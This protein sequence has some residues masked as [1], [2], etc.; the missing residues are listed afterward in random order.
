MAT[1]KTAALKK[2]RSAT[3][4]QPHPLLAH[5]PP[6]TDLEREQLEARIRT[7]GQ[8]EAIEVYQKQIIAGVYEYEACVATKTAPRFTE[9]EPVGDLTDYMMGRN[10]PRSMLDK[11]RACIAVLVYRPMAMAALRKKMTL[12]RKSP[13]GATRWY[14]HAARVCN[15]TKAN[16]EICPNLVKRLASILDEDKA[17][18]EAIRA[19]RITVMSDAKALIEE[20][21]WDHGLTPDKPTRNPNAAADRMEVL[22]RYEQGDKKPRDMSIRKLI[23]DLKREKRIKLLPPPT[24]KGKDWAVYEGDMAKEGQRI[25]DHSVNAVVADIIYGARDAPPMAVKVGKLSKRVLIEG[26]TLA[27]MCG[28]AAIPA[29]ITAIEKAG[30]SYFAVGF[31]DYYGSSGEGLK[32]K[33]CERMDCEPVVFFS[34][35]RLPDQKLVHLKFVSSRVSKHFHRWEKNTDAMIGL[36]SSVTGNG[37]GLVILDP[38][39]GS[40][41]TGHAALWTGNRFIGIEKNPKTAKLA[42]SRMVEVEREVK[43]RAANEVT[44][45]LTKARAA[46]DKGHGRDP[47]PLFD[48][49]PLSSSNSAST[50]DLSATARR[51]GRTTSC[52]RFAARRAC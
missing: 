30:M 13:E 19:R 17:I 24:P 15:V 18:F 27:V 34:S 42:Q 16:G 38:C 39:C 23:Y 43:D 37:K 50:A 41:T 6:L 21:R 47:R 4:L 49:S 8:R 45:L 46:N 20:L 1:P 31:L 35:A 9:V 33:F 29:V 25:K 7:Q 52:S 22:K 32:G 10:L 26:G 14:E 11:D 28:H 3:A 51:R 36:V 5:I 2:C 12:G 44:A 48:G 40:G